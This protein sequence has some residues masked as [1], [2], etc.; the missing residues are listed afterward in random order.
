MFSCNETKEILFTDL[1]ER[2]SLVSGMNPEKEQMKGNLDNTSH[3]DKERQEWKSL[4]KVPPAF[5]S[6]PPP[7]SLFSGGLL[8]EVP[9]QH[10]QLKKKTTSDTF[11][12]F[13]LQ[14]ETKLEKCNLAENI[15]SEEN[16]N[17]FV[18]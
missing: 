7:D 11:K 14:E 9:K 4:I 3:R 17:W 18:F 8:A 1:T 6:P 2:G 10:I 16:T 12:T 15:R 5:S 13:I